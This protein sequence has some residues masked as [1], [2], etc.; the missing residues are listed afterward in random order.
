MTRVRCETRRESYESDTQQ[1]DQT[2]ALRTG[3]VTCTALV[4]RVTFSNIECI[5]ADYKSYSVSQKEFTPMTCG[6]FTCLLHVPIYAGL[7]VFIQLP[8]T[9]TKLCHY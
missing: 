9:L 7:E 8:A 4:L 3:Y 1:L 2:L 5:F 6:N